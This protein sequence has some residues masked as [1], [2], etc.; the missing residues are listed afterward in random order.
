MERIG[1]PV[2]VLLSRSLAE[3]MDHLRLV[4]RATCVPCAAAGPPRWR[5]PSS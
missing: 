4:A 3:V 2:I 5:A 1:V